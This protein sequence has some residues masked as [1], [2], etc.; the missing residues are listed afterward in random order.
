MKKTNEK[1][2]IIK[3]YWFII[4]PIFAAF[5]VY[6]GSTKNLY[7]IDDNYVI[8]NHKL[9]NQGI[10]AIPEIFTSRYN[11]EKNQYFGY[12]PL[13]IAVY[14][15]EVSIFG[16]STTTHHLINVL[17]YALLI[18]VLYKLLKKLWPDI[19]NYFI[20]VVLT[21]F[22]VHPIHSEVVLSLKNREEILCL[23]F[24][25]LAWIQ[26]IVFYDKRKW[27]NLTI[28][29]GYL[30]LAFLAKESAIV[31]VA[32][33]PMSLYYFRFKT[34]EKEKPRS[35]KSIISIKR[36]SWTLALQCILLF[37]IFER[38]DF[39][40]ILL[41]EFIFPIITIFLLI[42]LSLRIRYK[43]FGK[44]N[45]LVISNPLLICSIAF[46]T[47]SLVLI[48]FTPTLSLYGVIISMICLISYSH[49]KSGIKLLKNRIKIPKISRNLI[50]IGSLA[51]VSGI[52]LSL[53]YFIPEMYLPEKNAPVYHWQNPLFSN[54]GTGTKI[55]IAFYSMIFYLK[56]LIIPHPLR[57][58]YGYALIPAANLSSGIVIISIL[59]HI[60]LLF[61]LFKG[62][63]KK[64]IWS[65][66]IAFYLIS[67][68]PFINILF[69]L[70]GIVAER[71]LFT[72]SLGFSIGIAYLIFKLFK[73]EINTIPKSI[74][75]KRILIIVSLIVIPFSVMTIQRNKDWKN[76][77]TLYEADIP[78]LEKS[79]KANNLYANYLIAKVYSGMEK[80]IPLQQMDKSIHSAINHFRQAINIDKTYANPYHNLGYIYL[81]IGRDYPTAETYFTNCIS[82]DTTIPETYMNRGVSR[83]YQDKF[84]LALQDL[85]KCQNFE[86]EK[87][88]DKVYYYTGLIYERNKD[89]ALAIQMFDSALVYSPR[90][91]KILEKQ[92]DIAFI[93]KRYNDALSYND[94]IISL[95]S[96]DDDKLW[97]D[98]GNYLLLKGDTLRA[99]K[100]WERAF[101]IYPGNYGIGM[102]LS[103]YYEKK[104]DANKASI[105]KNKAIKNKRHPNR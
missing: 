88:F 97:V 17:L 59:I 4:I 66:A 22:A 90:Q 51:I 24:A 16:Q 104:G 61:L 49:T 40:E 86:M 15:I 103:S 2:S 28:G 58:Y 56:L 43:N 18:F 10:K 84:E 101:E 91:I 39:I 70:T 52:V 73:V 23:L 82:I 38:P 19:S 25:T 69:P 20:F 74:S 1:T 64:E 67:I 102:T 95:I 77:E 79:A 54:P 41:G 71:L 78:K 81:I 63:R 85:K 14:A 7:N 5:I 57:F 55:G 105:I 99:I 29:L 98:K 92:K 93:Q 76:R 96:K 30:I 42:L 45:L 87:E 48:F 9:V 6:I 80:G 75:A 68:S 94:K 37:L 13:T 44:S 26:L 62:L 72:P 12:R 65:F 35:I 8:E 34:V 21:I 83:Y 60:F 33:I 50:I 36:T 3:R 53:I 31:F 100:A 89:T 11:I 46:F 47:L 32:I 27:F